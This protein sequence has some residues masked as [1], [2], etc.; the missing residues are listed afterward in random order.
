MS[1]AILSSNQ[2]S[3]KRRDILKI[4]LGIKRDYGCTKDEPEPNFNMTLNSQ[5]RQAVKRFWSLQTL[6]TYLSAPAGTGKSEVIKVLAIELAKLILQGKKK[7]TILVIGP[8][9]SAVRKLV[10]DITAMF[11]VAAPLLSFNPLVVLSSKES[12]KKSTKDA[13]WYKHTTLSKIK[14]LKFEGKLEAPKENSDKKDNEESPIKKLKN[15]DKRKAERY[16]NLSESTS[17]RPKGEKDMV[18]L[19]CKHNQQEIVFATTGML[20][21]IAEELKDVVYAFIDESGRLAWSNVLSLMSCFPQLEKLFITGDHL[22]LP[23]FTGNLTPALSKLWMKSILDV[24]EELQNSESI[25]L[26][27]NYRSHPAIVHGLK[28]IYRGLEHGTSLENRSKVTKFEAFNLPSRDIPIMFLHLSD[29][30]MKRN[31]DTTYMN[32]A[33][34]KLACQ[35]V[36]IIQK[37]KLIQ[38]VKVV[39]LCVYS[40][41]YFFLKDYFAGSNRIIVKTLDGYQGESEDLVILV[42]TRSGPLEDDE[43]GK[44]GNK[45]FNRY[46]FPLDQRRSVMALTRSKYAFALIGNFSLL[47]RGEVYSNFIRTMGKFTPICNGN[48]FTALA[49]NEKV[50]YI[51]MPL[52]DQDYR[53]DLRKQFILDKNMVE[54]DPYFDINEKYLNAIN[55]LPKKM[56]DAALANL[57]HKPSPLMKDDM[58]CVNAKIDKRWSEYASP[59]KFEICQES[60]HIALQEA[61]KQ[62]ATQERPSKTWIQCAEQPSSSQQSQVTSKPPNIL[63]RKTPKEYGKSWMFY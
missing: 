7:G 5:Q 8:T 57:Q 38:E 56:V 26:L 42:T 37:T 17:S 62:A 35:I 63:K 58:V 20:E 15:K 54:T 13:D 59:S 46:S 30:D 60:N 31:G 51:R 9:N 6:L 28:T 4:L 39:I 43:D 12:Q 19:V 53:L 40:G 33:Q 25:R 50:T 52:I 23:P 1:T 11:E 21:L 44:K 41:D 36:S 55:S 16:I 34:S 48:R 29:Q 18:S 3:G 61:L 14:Q 10:E 49:S 27:I 32:R 47:M 2:T 24:L 22:Q 45:R